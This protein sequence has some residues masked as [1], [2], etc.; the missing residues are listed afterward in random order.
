MVIH[1]RRVIFMPIIWFWCC[2]LSHVSYTSCLLWVMSRIRHV[3]YESCLVYVMSL[4]SL[5]S[6]TSCLTC[7]LN[8]LIHTRRVIFMP[9]LWLWCWTGLCFVWKVYSRSLLSYSRSLLLFSR[10]LF[11]CIYQK[12][13]TT[14]WCWAVC[15]V[16]G[17]CVWVCIFNILGR[18]K[19]LHICMD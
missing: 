4:M 16:Y 19:V 3:S 6:Y 10:C 18:A 7:P 15:V 5:V 9:I 12:R 2:C 13:P 17:R 11:V 1:T 8:A 14:R